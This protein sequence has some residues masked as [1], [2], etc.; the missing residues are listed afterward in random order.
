[1]GLGGMGVGCSTFAVGLACTGF[2]VGRTVAV[3]GFV[4]VGMDVF[5]QNNT[6]GVFAG[7][8]M[9]GRGV[10]GIFI[11]PTA[12]RVEKTIITMESSTSEKDIKTFTANAIVR[13]VPDRLERCCN[14][15]PH[16][17]KTGIWM[18]VISSIE[19]IISDI[20]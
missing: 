14:G 15:Y 12:V 19:I 3:T 7:L 20:W 9:V 4:T 1:V 13:V 16:S 2:W 11:F 18:M 10:P 6:S 17:G 8:V 5:F